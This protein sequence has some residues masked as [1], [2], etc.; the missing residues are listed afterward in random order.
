MKKRLF[1]QNAAV[2]S[3]TSL[4]LKGIGV[5]FRIW[6]SNHLGAEGMGLHQLIFSVYVLGSTIATTGLS[7]AVT[8]MVTE[9]SATGNDRAVPRVLGRALLLAVALSVGSTAVFYF[10]APLIGNWWIADA[11][12]IPALRILTFGFPFMGISATLKGY[13][14]A[15]RRAELPSAAQIFEQLT[16]I[17]ITVWLFS[18]TVERTV[19]ALC[20]AVMLSDILSEM[21]SAGFSAVCY[22][23]E[24]KRITPQTPFAKNDA[25]F[26]TKRLVGIAAPITA[27]RYLNTILRTIENIQVPR[28][29]AAFS[30]S[31]ELGLAAF[32][33]L[34]G[35]A[36]PLI[37]FPSSFL[38]AFST[39]LIPEMS[40]AM[41]LHR[42]IR[43]RQTA[44]VT[45]RI[46][47]TVSWLCAGCFWVLAY[48]LG[49]LFYGSTEVGFYLRVLAPL[50]PLMY[51]ECVV[52]G[53]LKG[54]NQQNR[55]LKYSILDS[56]LRI[57]MIALLVPRHGI[58]GF[59]YIMVISNLLTCL[60]NTGRL[61]K[62]ASVPPDLDK[63]I[64][65][66]VGSLL[67]AG[68]CA[69]WLIGS[70]WVRSLADIWIILIGGSALA[71]TYAAMLFFTKTFTFADLNI[72]SKKRS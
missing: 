58:R 21:L 2:L 23:L 43:V 24:H 42:S 36:M 49:A 20:F 9:A 41:A 13:F 3:G 6:L 70:T 51:L 4:L 7:T 5:F 68:S 19:T 26:R 32:G 25:D 15:R 44:D 64:L 63:W 16:R 72:V 14:Y 39:L 55:S 71:I 65:R 62:V 47:M 11:R 17:A 40:E 35:M 52:D 54:L 34:K 30:G 38:S 59:L 45:I 10:G 29:L 48:P 60:L 8:R 50:I 1:L 22:A 31:Q 66:P 28:C 46:T 57:V 67:I 18:G 69:H 27:G 37:F 12:A 61:C 33:N 56:G 53:I